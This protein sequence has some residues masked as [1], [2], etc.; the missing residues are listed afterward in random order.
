MKGKENLK[1]WSLKF[2]CMY[3]VVIVWALHFIW[4]QLC[5]LTDQ[6]TI[7]GT[8]IFHKGE[9][10]K[11]MNFIFRERM[12]IWWEEIVWALLYIHEKK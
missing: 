4:L 3:Y 12:D 7:A 5:I 8:L 2:V 1:A 6:M 10:G 11:Q 9:F